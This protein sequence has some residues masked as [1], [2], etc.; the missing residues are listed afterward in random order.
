M[1]MKFELM[2]FIHHLLCQGHI[3]VLC[4]AILT[5]WILFMRIQQKTHLIELEVVLS[6]GDLQLL[7]ME[8]YL[9]MFIQQE[10]L[11][12]QLQVLPQALLYM[13]I[14]R[15]VALQPPAV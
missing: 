2:Q 6:F 15:I 7:H 1:I 9:L 3:L 12:A 13:E 11:V 14:L 8:L 4:M 10:A 5:P